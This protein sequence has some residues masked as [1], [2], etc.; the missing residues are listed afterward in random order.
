M[1]PARFEG[2]IALVTGAARGIGLAT[3]ERL[4]REGAAV[5]FGDVLDELGL[6]HERRLKA[7]GHRVLYRRLDV[8]DTGS[9]RSFMASALEEFGR[10]DVLV[11]NAAVFRPGSIDT[12]TTADFRAVLRVNVGGTFQMSQLVARHMVETARGG[13]IVNLSSITAEQGAPG[14][15]AYSSSKGAISALTR[16]LAMA[17]AG[18]DIRVNAVAPGMIAT[19]N[20]E[21]INASAPEIYR[22]VLSRTPLRRLGEPSEVA[23]VV[24]FLASADASYMTGQVLY[25]DGGRLALSYTIPVPA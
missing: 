7:A 9:A 19:E 10:V 20:T 13:A 2:R 1:T 16:S 25:P 21:D 15:L 22:Q 5:A 14:L 23:S 12:A 4:A 6:E 18:Y 8:T 11:N 17:L 24:A 3:V